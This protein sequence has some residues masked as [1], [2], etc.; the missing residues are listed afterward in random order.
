[1]LELNN[2]AANIIQAGILEV[3]EKTTAVL[4]TSPTISYI[5]QQQLGLLNP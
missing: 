5:K 3:S 1:M 2:Y 4:E